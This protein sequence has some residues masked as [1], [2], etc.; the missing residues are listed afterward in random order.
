MPDDKEK[1]E[2]K[3]SK[4][5]QEKPEPPKTRV[6]PFSEGGDEEVT[7]TDIPFSQEDD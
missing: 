5:Q 6:K 3:P 7:Y 2:E 4:P 1:P